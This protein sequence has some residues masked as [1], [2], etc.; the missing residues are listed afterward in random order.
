MDSAYPFIRFFVR[1]A[2]LLALGVSAVVLIVGLIAVAV[3]LPAW[4]LVAA[5]VL[6]VVVFPLIRLLG[7]LVALIADTLLPQ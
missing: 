1:Y 5:I 7:E 2:K 3:G 4:V 6:A